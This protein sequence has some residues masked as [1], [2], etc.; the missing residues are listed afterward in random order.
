MRPEPSPPGAAAHCS[1][2]T[3]WRH[4][5]S[6]CS[7]D[8][9]S[10]SSCQRWPHSSQR[11]NTWGRRCRVA[12][13]WQRMLYVT[14][15]TC[16]LGTGH[17]TVWEQRTPEHRWLTPNLP[18]TL[19]AGTPYSP[20]LHSRNGHHSDTRLTSSS[21][22]TKGPLGSSLVLGAPSRLD[23]EV[24]L[25]LRSHEM[26]PMTAKHAKVVWENVN[27]ILLPTIRAPAATP[28]RL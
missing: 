15:E 12:K 2:V 1:G 24:L 8:S 7:R 19:N 22:A 3:S 21:C 11:G 25:L 23:C 27:A 4:T 17:K 20:F 5:T 10:R 9:S 6:D 16:S 28:V 26:P 18:A 14:R 13:C